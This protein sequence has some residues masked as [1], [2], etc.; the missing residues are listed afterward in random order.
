MI[1]LDCEKSSSFA[2]LV[3]MCLGFPLFALVLAS[4][5]VIWVFLEWSIWEIGG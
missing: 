1:Y 4:E 3:K 5:F 2:G